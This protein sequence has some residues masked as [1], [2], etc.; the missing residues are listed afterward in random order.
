[1][2]KNDRQYRITKARASDFEDALRMS[3]ARAE[4][5]DALFDRLQSSAIQSQLEDLS[6]ELHEYEQLRSSGNAA[7]EITTFEDIP[8]SLIKARIAAGFTQKQLAEKLHLKEQQIQR[9]E[10]GDYAKASVERLLQIT[11][12]LGVR[13][14]SGMLIR[15][16]SS[17]L[18]SL[19]EKLRG[20]GWERNFVENR[21]LP[22]GLQAQLDQARQLRTQMDALTGQ[23]TSSVARVLRCDVSTLLEESSLEPNSLAIAGVQ[24]KA[25]KGMDEKRAN[26]YSVY[27]HYLG[28][29]LLQAT[30]H[31]M[32]QP[33]P[34]DPRD[35]KHDI[36]Q[37]EGSF[38]LASLLRYLWA[39]GIAVLPLQ[40]KGTFHA[41]YWR[42]SGRHVIVLKQRTASEARW[43][44][45]LL[46]ETRHAIDNP[47]DETTSL[48]EFNES[49]V[50]TEDE[51]DGEEEATHFA[52]EC[53]LDGRAE[54]LVRSAH[55]LSRQDLRRLKSAITEISSREHVDVGLFANYMAYR[56][57]LQGVNWWGA[58]TNLQLT[59]QH[60]W[61]MAKDI[62]LHHARFDLLSEFDRDLLQR[63]LTGEGYE[64]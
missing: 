57:S 43:I 56:L 55:Q 62:L 26:A 24:F 50:P 33:I 18:D 17:P 3:R 10:S 8:K 21:I 61:E 31:L 9:Y 28:L 13:V 49:S 45:D 44:I 42:V 34:S 39:H 6:Q 41:A 7:I 29:L 54:E 25:P 46:H 32:T 51:F 23:I 2:I 58:A 16:C 64:R 14:D 52:G 47:N 20:F 40:D 30:P 22:A 35:L 63:A 48:I 12:A 4:S 1:M 37:S 53:A 15:T 60:P 27:A 19:F 59:G 36:I 5:S 38:N 11:S